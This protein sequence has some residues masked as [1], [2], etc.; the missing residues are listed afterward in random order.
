MVHK[1]LK[2]TRQFHRIKQADLAKKLEIS[3]SYLSE[4]ENGSKTISVDLLHKYAT[5]FDVP[6][7]TFLRFKDTSTKLDP[8]RSERA[9]RLLAFLQWVAS[10]EDRAES[11]QEN[12]EAAPGDSDKTILN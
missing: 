1:A 4:I 11:D 2:L 8:R 3:P 9:E 12:D 6:V 10:D 5:I 7:D